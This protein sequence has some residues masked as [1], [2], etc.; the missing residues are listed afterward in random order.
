[1]RRIGSALT[2]VVC[3]AANLRAQSADIL[4]GRLAGNS[5]IQE[6][7]AVIDKDPIHLSREFTFAEMLYRQGL[8]D[9]REDPAGNVMAIR[10]G[11]PDQPLL[12]VAVHLNQ[13]R[14]LAVVLAI[15]RAMDK[16]E[17]STKNSILFIATPA[18]HGANEDNRLSEALE[19]PVRDAI[20]AFVF[21]DAVSEDRISIAPKTIGS[22]IVQLASQAIGA[23]G[24]KPKFDEEVSD[25]AGTVSMKIPSVGIG[26]GDEGTHGAKVAM[27]IILA[28]AG[29]M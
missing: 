20:R 22:T 11:Q 24:M 17:L 5:R 26:L 10:K 14:S 15:L 6:A 25:I 21:A 8:S 23:N 19:S 2:L 12:A 9:I 28:I 1:M 13:E 27:T 7:C 16:A 18:G 29:I 3:L 4:V